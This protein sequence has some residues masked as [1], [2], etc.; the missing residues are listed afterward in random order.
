MKTVP[1]S[2]FIFPTTF[3]GLSQRGDEI[4]IFE[5]GDETTP[6]WLALHPPAPPE[7]EQPPEE[8]PAP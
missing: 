8:P 5:P 7:D 6:E 4:T 1:V 2:E 3:I